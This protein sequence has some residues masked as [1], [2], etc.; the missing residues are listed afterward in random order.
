MVGR[1]SKWEMLPPDLRAE[2]EEKLLNRSITPAEAGDIIRSKGIDMSDMAV[3][4]AYMKLKKGAI[5]PHILSTLAQEKLISPKEAL[6]HLTSYLVIVENYL[7]ALL[8]EGIDMEKF[9][10]VSHAIEQARRLLEA[11][12]RVQMMMPSVET[13]REEL[14]QDFME[15]LEQAGLTLEQLLKVKQY[16]EA[17]YGPKTSGS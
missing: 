13:S 5:R 11:I 15:S 16:F 6:D 14:I 4:R 9:P 8:R 7:D 12:E 10:R 17:K 2:L 3:Y 1:K